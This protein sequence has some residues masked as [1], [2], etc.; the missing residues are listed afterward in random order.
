MARAEGNPAM[1]MADDVAAVR[2][3]PPKSDDGLRVGSWVR[4]QR[5]K[6]AVDIKTQ[7]TKVGGHSLRQLF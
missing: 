3:R 4:K 2:H 6:E 5:S 7:L 1:T